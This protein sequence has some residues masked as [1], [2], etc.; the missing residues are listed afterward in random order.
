MNSGKLIEQLQRTGEEHEVY[1]VTNTALGGYAKFGGF[2]NTRL[3]NEGNNE[4]Q[5][6][7]ILMSEQEIESASVDALETFGGLVFTNQDLYK[8]IKEAL[9]SSLGFH[10]GA[11]G[12]AMAESVMEDLFATEYNQTNREDLPF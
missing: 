1:M 12:R 10:F 2:I 8:R 6:A 7:I 5:P 11:S 3:K 9:E 4:A